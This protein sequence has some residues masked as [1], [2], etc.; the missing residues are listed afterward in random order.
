MCK[1]IQ[2]WKDT[3]QIQVL[4]GA[5]VGRTGNS[6]RFINRSVDPRNECNYTIIQG[7]NRRKDFQKGFR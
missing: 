5:L 4:K 7:M 2:N 1:S 3:S 6:T